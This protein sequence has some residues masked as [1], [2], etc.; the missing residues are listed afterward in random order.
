[1]RL[2]RRRLL[3]VALPLTLVAGVALAAQPDGRRPSNA[4]INAC[5]KKKDGRVR[6]VPVA[7]S[8]RRNEQA[9]SWNAKGQPGP[10]GPTGAAGQSG[11]TGPAGPP[12][13][14]ESPARRA[15]RAHLA[16]PGRPVPPDRPG[17]RARLEQVSARSRA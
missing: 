15:M 8:C 6:I 12:G 16:P 9:V 14:Q 2:P 3:L 5:V 13:P 7:A 11:P 4:V 10:A 17:R 1:M